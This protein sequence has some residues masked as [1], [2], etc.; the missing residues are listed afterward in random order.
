MTLTLTYGD[1]RTM[2]MTLKMSKLSKKEY[3]P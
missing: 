2:I 1:I 3:D